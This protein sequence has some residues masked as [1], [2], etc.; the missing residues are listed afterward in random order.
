MEAYY[1]K[2]MYVTFITQVAIKVKDNIMFANAF[3]KIK[4]KHEAGDAFSTFLYG[5]TDFV[6]GR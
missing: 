4:K 5:K 6:Y 1:A 3:A 2:Y